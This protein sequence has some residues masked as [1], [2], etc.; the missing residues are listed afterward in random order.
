[1]TSE[2]TIPGRTPLIAARGVVAA[3][4]P[5]ASAA[6]LAAMQAGG[7]AMDGALAAAAV[8]TVVQPH[9]STLGGDAFILSYTAR[10]EKVTAINASGA[11]PRSAT[12]ARYRADGG[13]PMRGPRAVAGPGVVAGWAEAHSLAGRLSWPR[14]FEA[15]IDY[16]EHGFPVSARLSAIAGALADVLREHPAS[17]RQYLPSG[18]PP[19]AGTVLRQQG[20]ARTLRAVAAEGRDGFYAG[21]VARAIAAAFRDSGGLLDLDDLRDTAAEV[22]EPVA[23]DYRGFRVLEQPPVSQGFIVLAAL[24]IVE[25]FDLAALS[26]PDRIHLL[27]EAIKLAF[28]DRFAHAGDPRAVTMP[29]EWL[30]SKERA[31]EQRARL[32]EGSVRDFAPPANFPVPGDTTYIAAMDA[33]GNTAG[34]I[35]SV[36]AGF[37]SGFVAGETGVLFNNRLTGFTLEPGH[38]NELAPGKRTV[39]TL[40]SYLVLRDDVPVIVGGT[41]GADRQVM[42]NLQMLTAMLDLGAEP[43]T[44]QDLPRWSVG[45][46]RTIELEARF[47]PAIHESL[48]ARGWSVADLEAWSPRCGRAQIIRRDPATGAL[49]AASDLRGE[50]QPAGW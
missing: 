22:M 41:P 37:G 30:I 10:D 13:I 24:N 46:G 4:H 21:D 20:L 26:E 19:A 15:A 38:P 28:E 36:F 7:T 16:A 35:Q 18:E 48:I 1:M 2:V 49:W 45:R 17:A 33:E 23:T 47:A 40:N 14:L 44:A 42:T 25:G 50:G 3:D 29:T 43:A 32:T 31:A 27:A 9:F 11:A 12:A 6:G 39:H 34:L 8:M 5:L